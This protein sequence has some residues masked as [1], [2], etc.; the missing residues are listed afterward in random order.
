[1]RME[2]GRK[3][4]VKEDRFSAPVKGQIDI[5]RISWWEKKFQRIGDGLEQLLT[6]CAIPIWQR[7]KIDYLLLELSFR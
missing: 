5:S 1:M 6:F 3:G 7:R 4:N 2:I